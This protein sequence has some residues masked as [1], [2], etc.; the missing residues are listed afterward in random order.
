MTTK[1]TPLYILLTYIIMMLFSSI[2]SIIVEAIIKLINP[3]IG[4]IELFHVNYG[5]TTFITFLLGFLVASFFILRDKTFLKNAFIK[6]KPVTTSVAILW[7]FIGFILVLIAQL[8]AGEIE[9]RLG[10]TTVSHNTASLSAVAAIAPI[11]IISIVFFGP[12]LEE[13]VFRRVIFASLNQTTNFIVAA[14]VSAIIFGLIHRDFSHILTYVFTGLVF[15]YLY[16]KTQRL[17]TTILAHMLLNAFVL[18]I[19]LNQYDLMQW[20]KSITNMFN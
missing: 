14:L 16:N 11:I 1:K 4:K 18:Y 20:I 19:Q 9:E 6:S 8:I 17:L 13:V 2:I 5:W 12:F 15:A 3:D 10:V 7:G